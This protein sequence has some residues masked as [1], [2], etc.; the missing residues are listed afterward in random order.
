MAASPRTCADV[1]RVIVQAGCPV[2]RGTLVR[3][4]GYCPATVSASVQRLYAQGQITP[5]GPER[6]VG[7]ALRVWVPVVGG[8]MATPPEPALSMSPACATVLRVVRESERPVGCAAISRITGYEPRLVSAS[9]RSL[10]EAGRVQ[11]PGGRRGSAGLATVWEVVP[12]VATARPGT[13]LAVPQGHPDAVW[14]GCLERAGIAPGL[15][16]YAQ[17]GSRT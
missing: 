16:S 1:Y 5:I 7:S 10:R 2:G 15:S 6:G 11:Q 3:R 14:S 17:R 9:M 4:T 8:F 13:V 12:G